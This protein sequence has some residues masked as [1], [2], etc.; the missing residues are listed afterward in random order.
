M[1]IYGARAAAADPLP[2]AGPAGH[3]MM[4][5]A[6]RSRAALTRRFGG[7]IAVERASISRRRARA[8]CV[9]IIGP[10]GAGK[11]TLFNLIS[12]HR[13]PGRGH[14]CTSPAR[15]SPAL[16]PERLAALGLARTFQHGRVFANLSVLDN[17]LVGAHTRLRARAA[18][19]CRCS[20]R[21]W[22][23][24]LALLAP[25]AGARGGS[26]RCA[27]RRRRSWRCSATGCCR[28]STSP[29]TACPT[30][31]AAASRSPARW[32]CGRA[33]CCSTSRPPA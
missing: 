15:T 31:T 21:C 32:R 10:N 29:P 24:L 17:V 6:A 7:V 33:C 25:A 13:P 3:G 19:A 30:P 12:G 20:G 16:A 1:L 2:P 26:A 18:A 11:T 22:N 14:A 27:R 4:R 9:S 8:S 23:S 28:A 5:G